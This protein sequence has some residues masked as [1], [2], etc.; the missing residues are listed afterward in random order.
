MVPDCKDSHNG[1]FESLGILKQGTVSR[2]HEDTPLIYQGI[3]L[4]LHTVSRSRNGC[5]T[6]LRL[7]FSYGSNKM[8][9]KQ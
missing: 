9:E 1:W 3:I 2:K 7:T 4:I 8:Q 5:C 6:I